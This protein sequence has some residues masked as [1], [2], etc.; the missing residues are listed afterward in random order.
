MNYLKL[1]EVSLAESNNKLI[2]SGSAGR[3]QGTVG[4][5]SYPGLEQEGEDDTDEEDEEE[6]E[7]EK[8]SWHRS[9]FRSPWGKPG[10]LPPVQ[11]PEAVGRGSRRTVACGFSCTCFI[12]VLSSLPA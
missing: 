10:C 3:R 7:K 9:G 4:P 8:F 5:G 6:E 12:G 1:L 2:T 11:P